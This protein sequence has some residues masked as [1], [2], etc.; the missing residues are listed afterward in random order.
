MDYKYTAKSYTELHKQEQEKKLNKIR[1]YL[2]NN[3]ISLKNKKI[4]DV[5][6]GTGI[7]T[8]FFEG[9]IGLEPEIEMIKQGSYNAIQGDAENL[10]FK[11]NTF[12]VVISVTAIHN[13]EDFEKAILEIKRVLKPKYLLVITLLRKSNRFEEIKQVIKKEFDVVE[14]DEEKDV[15]FISHKS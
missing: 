7:S 3:K 12:D 5:G 1:E 13:V 14:I 6:S 15:I 8:E 10:P 11:D 2:D 9:A 4:L